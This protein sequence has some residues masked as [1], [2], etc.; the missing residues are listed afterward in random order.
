[1]IPQNDQWEHLPP[2]WVEKNRSRTD[3]WFAWRPVMLGALGMGRIVWLR[4][5][6]RNRCC[7]V[8]IYQEA[9]D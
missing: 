7:G 6:W 3:I 9:D 8:T 4:P 5:V 1:M 2:A